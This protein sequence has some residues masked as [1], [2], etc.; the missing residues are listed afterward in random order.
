MQNL[1]IF[2]NETNKILQKMDRQYMQLNHRFTETQSKSLISSPLHI[3]RKVDRV[4]IALKG[5]ST[6]LNFLS[7][8]EQDKACRKT[9]PN[10]GSKKTAS[11]L[12]AVEHFLYD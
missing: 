9:D 12:F 5:S 8:T 10:H 11:K 3:D 7:T 1:N 2:V 6:I 4:Y